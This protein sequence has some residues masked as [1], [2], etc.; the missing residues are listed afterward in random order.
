[1][2]QTLKVQQKE[3]KDDAESENIVLCA[4][5]TQRFRTVFIGNRI[6][7]A[8]ENIKDVN[9]SLLYSAPRICC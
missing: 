7:A 9:C 8:Y 6:R 1:M 4:I 3:Y 2:A 5:T